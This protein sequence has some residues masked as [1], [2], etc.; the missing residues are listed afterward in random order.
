MTIGT[1]VTSSAKT[2]SSVYKLID[3]V[4]ELLA[5]LKIRMEN[6]RKTLKTFEL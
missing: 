4:N 1:P 6:L 5:V 3:D 2:L